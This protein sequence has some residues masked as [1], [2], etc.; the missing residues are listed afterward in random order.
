MKTFTN[1]KISFKLFIAV[2][3]RGVCQLFR[4]VGEIFGY[5]DESSYG[6]VVWR[7]SA[8]CLALLLSAFTCVFLYAFAEEVVYKK[9][10]RPIVNDHV[11]EEKHISNHVV[12]QSMY[13]SDNTR[14][15]DENKKKVLLKDVDWVFVS[16]D[17][18]SLAV[19]S[20]DNK[21]GY[22]NRFTGKVVIPL[23]YSRAW[24]FSEGLAAVE[25][26]G[27]LLFI[28]HSGKVVI[29]KDFQVH[30]DEPKYAFKHG[31]C[32][33]KDPVSGKMGL[34][35]KKGNWA[36]APE[37]ESIFNSRG[38][39]K[40]EKE[41]YFGLYSA[42]MKN[43]FPTDNA[44]IEIDDHVIE[45]RHADHTAKRYDFNGNVV[46]DFVI[47][48]ISNMRYETK[49]LRNDLGLDVCEEVDYK[50][51][52]IANCQRYLVESKNYFLPDYYGL[53]NR[54]G[55]I[56]TGPIYTS[57]EAISQNLYLCQPDGVIINDRGEIVK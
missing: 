6:K 18:D 36:L 29:D 5:S 15:Y 25:K 22:L 51:Y 40:V 13:Y 32:I 37:Y 26:D 2:L 14:I 30:F 23:Q 4:S 42:D 21:R 54:D 16:D 27:E 3:W 50:I 56:V 38:F 45:V 33:I 55:K 52:G 57:I 20:K 11:W 39:W 28:D 1:K 49:E 7:V 8:T 53:L 34:I 43:L 17:K 35:D 19:F 24:I 12:F 46:V 9:W 47:D 10:L 41:G 31:Y 44:Q 48:E